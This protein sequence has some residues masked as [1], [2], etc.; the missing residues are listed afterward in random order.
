METIIPN[1]NTPVAII[2]GSGIELRPLLDEIT[3][4]EPIRQAIDAPPIPGHEC[5]FIFGTCANRPI[6]LQAGRRH[7]YEGLSLQQVTQSVDAL[8]GLGVQHLILTNAA[9]GI[10]KALRPGH[11]AAATQ[12]RTWPYTP[13]KLPRELLP[14][15]AI[16][17]CDHAGPYRWM[18][19]PC[20]ETQAEI[21]ALDNLGD[22]TV[23]MS[24]APEMHRC[25]QLGIKCALIACVTNACAIPHALSHEAVLNV[26]R[27]TS[28][29]LRTLLKNFLST[30]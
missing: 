6:I 12:V 2:A 5:R 23:G 8:H 10:D 11:L 20:Y 21:R 19:G 30:P 18:H 17:Q 28:Q 3:K 1:N 14:D 15:F 16:P 25:K 27:Q 9:G 26:A 24:A 13:Q 7:L 4:E 22:A 29:R